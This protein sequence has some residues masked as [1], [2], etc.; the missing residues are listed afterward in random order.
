MNSVL[1]S[2]SAAIV[3]IISAGGLPGIVVLMALE[4]ACIPIP[5]EI[6]MPFGGYLVSTGQFSLLGVA[7][8]GAVGCNLGSAIAYLAG[9]RGGRALV[10]RL[11]SHSLFGMSELTMAER[12]FDRFGSVA[13]FLGRLLPVIRTF[14]ALPAGMARM[15]VWA[16]HAYTFAGSWLWCYALAYVGKSLGNHWE[17]DPRLKWAF[18]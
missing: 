2:V 8:A 10:E 16:F 18:R 12:F 1:A 17:D 7:T 4:S 11:G 6:V 5:S 13:T 14:I 9:A 3:S 15:N